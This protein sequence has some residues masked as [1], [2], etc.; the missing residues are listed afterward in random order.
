MK[1]TKCMKTVFA[2]V[3]AFAVA[4]TSVPV[5]LLA[6]TQDAGTDAAATLDPV[7]H[8]NMTQ[9]AD[10]TLKD[11]TGNGHNGIADGKV[12]FSDIDHTPVVNLNGGA[13][14]IPDGTISKD[15]TE[16]TVNMLLVEDS[17]EHKIYMDVVSWNIKKP[18]YLSDGLCESGQPYAW[19]VML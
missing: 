15:A 14:T 13:V 19:W 11:V 5:N 12:E 17:K 1:F 8:W 3:M 9:D 18:L 7:L 2:G 4:A 10:G 6:E 16:V